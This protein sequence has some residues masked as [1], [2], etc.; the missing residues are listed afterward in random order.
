MGNSQPIMSAS[1][2]SSGTA[3]DVQRSDAGVEGN[4]RLTSATGIVLIVMLAVEGYTIL[5]VQSLITLHIFL[6]IMLVGPVLLK[7]AATLYRFVRYYGGSPAYV[8]KGPPH[9]VLRVLGPLVTLSSLAVLGT[10]LGLLA[11][12]DRGGWLLTAHQASFIVWV[13]VMTI[14]V[15][16]HVREAAVTS[17]REVRRRS[18]RRLWRL[19]ALAA[20][21]LIGVG[22]AAALLPSAT[23]WTHRSHDFGNHRPR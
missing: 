15:L 13:S 17:W 20:A 23:H 3:A 9:I 16:G 10:G 14:H 1:L 18:P 5:D 4:A 12:T 11:V 2:R 7:I 22:G 6:G 8:R 21:L 19:A